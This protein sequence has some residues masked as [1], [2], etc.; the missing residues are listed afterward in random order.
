MRVLII[1]ILVI[2]LWGTFLSFVSYL[3]VPTPAQQTGDV[4]NSTGEQIYTGEVLS[5]TVFTGENK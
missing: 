1:I 3:M 2:F 5:W 4:Q